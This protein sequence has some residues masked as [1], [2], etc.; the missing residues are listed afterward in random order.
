M[1]LTSA[2]KTRTHNLEK[3]LIEATFEGLV[4]RGEAGNRAKGSNFRVYVE[5][6]LRIIDE[7]PGCVGGVG[8]LFTSL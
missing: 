5:I 3:I 1:F 8:F 7:A 6:K 2:E 4:A